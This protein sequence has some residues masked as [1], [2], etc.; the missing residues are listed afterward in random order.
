[1]S[2]DF[3]IS[4]HE[5]SYIPADLGTSVGTAHSSNGP[6]DNAG[7]DVARDITTRKLPSTPAQDGDCSLAKNPP[8]NEK[9]ETPLHPSSP[10]PSVYDVPAS[11]QK[12]Q[13]P[14]HSDALGQKAGAGQEKDGQYFVLEDDAA[15]EQATGGQY[16]VLEDDAAGSAIAKGGKAK[17]THQDTEYST[18]D[19][20]D[21]VPRDETGQD[22]VYT[23]LDNTQGGKAAAQAFETSSEFES[24]YSL[25]KPI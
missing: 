15:K 23:A 13:T 7:Y 17:R 4:E 21:M 6:R 20:A 9:K 8:K 5:Y 11:T 12:K 19:R 16:F 1:M 14:L 2:A 24:D 10:Q 3:R 22:S 18:L 25:Q